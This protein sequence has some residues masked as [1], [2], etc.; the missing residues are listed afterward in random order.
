[1]LLKGTVLIRGFGRKLVQ[2]C[3]DGVNVLR[4][5]ED[6][7]AVTVVTLSLT[8]LWYLADLSEHTGDECIGE[9]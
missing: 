3:G 1:M 6:I 4:G 2:N 5:D 8:L 9:D 7:W